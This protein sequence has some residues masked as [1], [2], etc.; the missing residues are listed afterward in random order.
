VKRVLGPLAVAAGAL[1]IGV[2]GAQAAPGTFDPETG[3]VTVVNEAGEGGSYELVSDVPAA[4]GDTIS[5]E[6]R[7][8]DVA[9][10]GGVPRVFI[11]GGAYN[12]FDADPAGPGACGTDEDG[13][14]WF[15]VVGTISG[16][17]DGTA[18]QVGF[19]NDN[20]AD[21]G[22][23]EFRN[24]TINGVSVLPEPPATSPKE[25]CKKGG[26]RELGF[27][28]QGQCVKALARQQ[29]SGERRG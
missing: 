17:V 8:S 13:D 27:R 6:Y 3:I 23:V 24:L 28:N 22:T 21:P 2:S 14:G 5:F 16:I 4:N 25:R 20:P 15:T 29:G 18:G 7:T 10:A 1:A 19:V 26:W 9:C 12:T 11:Q